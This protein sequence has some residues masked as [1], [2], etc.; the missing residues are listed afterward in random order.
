MNYKKLLKLSIFVALACSAKSGQ[1][2]ENVGNETITGDILNPS[3]I[4]SIQQGAMITIGESSNVKLLNNSLTSSDVSILVRNGATLTFDENATS[5]EN[6]LNTLDITNATIKGTSIYV[7]ELK[8]RENSKMELNT[9]NIN[10]S[11]T[12]SGVDNSAVSITGAKPENGDYTNLTLENNTSITGEISGVSLTLSDSSSATN[13]NG[14]TIISIGSG[15]ITTIG[16]TY[17][18]TATTNTDTK[19]KITDTGSTFNGEVFAEILTLTESKIE[20]A[21]SLNADTLIADNISTGN[22]LTQNK[23]KTTNATFKA[24]DKMIMNFAVD[25]NVLE[26]TNTTLTGIVNTNNIKS[27]KSTFARRFSTDNLTADNSNF[28]LGGSEDTYVGAII[29]K[30]STSGA[31]NT[32]SL[33]GIV[34]GGKLQKDKI[35]NLPLAV[36]KKGNGNATLDGF[37]KEYKALDG[38]DLYNLNPKYISKKEIDGYLVYAL[39]K[40]GTNTDVSSI[41]FQDGKKLTAE[42]VTDI[43]NKTN[44]GIG[45]FVNYING[46]DK[47]INATFIE[48][49]ASANI[50]DKNTEAPEG[51]PNVGGGSSESTESGS[52]NNPNG[53]TNPDSSG[54]NNSNGSD[55]NTDLGNGSSNNGN[56]NSNNSSNGSNEN[57]NPTTP[58]IP[59]LN[60][61]EAQA[62]KITDDLIQQVSINKK[63]VAE[64]KS[65]GTSISFAH[66]FE[67]NNLNKRMGD[68]RNQNGE[69]GIWSR[70]ELTK[71][72]LND[73]KLSFNEIQVGADKK[74]SLN[75]GDLFVGFMVNGSNGSDENNNVKSTNLG[76]GLYSAML[77]NNGYFIDTVL[78]ISNYDTKFDHDMFLDGLKNN[79]TGFLGSFE[80]GKRFDSDIFY[81]EPSASIIISYEPGINL[82]SKVASIV[83]SDTVRLHTKA[84]VF[85]GFKLNDNINLRLGLGYAADLNNSSDIKLKSLI[86]KKEETIKGSKYHRGFANIGTNVFLG[87]NTRINLEYEKSFGGDL[88]IDHQLNATL[89]Y[90]F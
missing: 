73:Y 82:S 6:R 56:D 75:N 66:A 80:F 31:N 38:I 4:K 71:A 45:S 29:S 39:D 83:S 43:A 81:V 63:A 41:N 59:N 3:T 52:T 87:E 49:L 50:I 64:V 18:D 57:T 2:L 36:L 90:S 51:E 26:A 60:N 5:S 62:V 12:L 74:L 58:N 76:L 11:S 89:R 8:A 65:L 32:I 67:W 53:N 77:F 20:N 7:G 22:K 46:V 19:P 54:S 88:S 68:I 61:Q 84:S 48:K 33:L 55:N 69:F 10:Q 17:Q 27:E 21:I 42:N 72:S 44:G 47:E 28:I 13:V 15:S 35:A 24:T 34:S 37:I 40:S 9:I 78:R 14:G 25:T 85:S 1:N 30:N 70:F 23:I 79:N 16:S 86:S